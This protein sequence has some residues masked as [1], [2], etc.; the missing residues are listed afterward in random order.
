MNYA[1]IGIVSIVIH[2]ILNHEYLRGKVRK[3]ET[4]D[5]FRRYTLAA[6]VYSATDALWGIVYD[7]HIPGLLYLNT[8][9][10]YAAMTLTVVWLC[11]YIAAYLH[12]SSGFGRF[13]LCFSYAFSALTVFLLIVNHFYHIFFWIHPDGSYQAYVIRYIA[14]YLLVILCVILLFQIRITI[15]K[16]EEEMR[17][18]YITI[19][20]FCVVLTVAIAAQ[21][22][23]PLLPLYSMGLVIGISMIHTFVDRA[24]K[25]EQ[26]KVLLSMAEI[27]YS[28]HVVDLSNDTVQEFSAKGLA[29]EDV[30]RA[31]GAAQ[32]MAKITRLATTDEH[33]DPA[34]QFTDLSTLAE[35]MKGKNV[36]SAKFQGKEVGWFLAMFI[37]A[38][39]DAEGKPT[40]VIFTTRIIDDEKK[41]E[42]QLLYQSLRDELTGLYNRRAY[43]DDL[44]QG[45]AIPVEPDLVY[46]AVDING[47]KEVNDNLGHDAGDELIQATAACLKQV[48]G[49]CGKVYRT[50]GDEFVSVFFADDIHL[51]K[52]LEDL[53]QRMTAWKGQLVPSM[54]LSVG[55][56]AGREFPNETMSRI[57]KIADERMYLFKA[58]YYFQKGI[59]RRGLGTARTALFNLYAK[60]LK[61]D[62][63]RDSYTIIQMDV[64]EQTSEKGFSTTMSGWFSGFGRSGQVHPEDLGDYLNQ[65]DLV[66]LQE[67]FRSGKTFLSIR[68]RRKYPEGFKY[69]SMDLIPADDYTHDHQTLFLYVK[70]SEM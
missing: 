5:A 12:L 48:F 8:L 2:L 24:E 19:F 56:V 66:Y 67:Y 44:L 58:K 61:I 9:L 32:M 60:I 20:W 6:L 11:R 55:C 45:P 52:I 27:Y 35:R 34:L 28:M 69:S 53:E 39:V 47:L 40:R 42:E 7:L 50:G 65:T 23:F 14:L 17:K 63:T 21:I 70:N 57:A 3:C 68:Y 49:H 37:T 1:I 31:N 54:S 51:K 4:N 64:A 22:Q 30:H 29:R 10:Y 13:I 26:N 43:E 38:A 18:R 62:L 15:N 41:Q 33:L 59:D 16:T 46:V 36:L 25:E